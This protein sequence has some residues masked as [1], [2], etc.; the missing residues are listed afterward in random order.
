MD[1]QSWLSTNWQPLLFGGVLGLILGWLLTWLPMS[2]TVKRY[3]TR[4]QQLESRLGES[5][6]ALADARQQSQMLEAG[7]SASEAN[8]D[9]T[10]GQVLSLQ[11]SM[12]RLV[13]G[14]ATE[15]VRLEALGFELDD[16]RATNARLLE[17]NEALKANLEGFSVDLAKNRDEMDSTAQALTRTRR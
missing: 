13:G 3:Q 5:E 16:L 14:R 11:T 17:E 7:L 12:E 6:K 2:G 1:L 4:A 9:E 15:D 8:L 10:R